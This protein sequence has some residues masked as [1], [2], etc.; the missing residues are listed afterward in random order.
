MCLLCLLFTL[1]AYAIVTDME[2]LSLLVAMIFAAATLY[3]SVGHAGASGYLAAMAL[4]GVAPATMRPTSLVLNVLVATI[5]TYSF[6]KVGAF[7]WPVLWPFALASVPLAFIGG[8]LTLPGYVYKPVV[9][10][11][12]LI[13]AY[14]LLWQTWQAPKADHEATKPVPIAAALAWGAAIGLLSGL[15]G[16]GGGIFLT[17]LLLFMGWA[18]TRQ[19]AG[20]SAAFILVNSLAGIAGAVSSLQRIPPEIGYLAVAAVLGGL[21]GTQLGTRRFGT[22]GLSRA[23]ALVLLVAGLKMLFT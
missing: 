9:A 12:L 23:L 21:L 6:Y 13:A 19:V 3:S 2:N 7:S 17:P 4:V 20:V 11:V 14:R 5:A 10:V 1:A 16:V 18:E 8:A 22:V 15:T